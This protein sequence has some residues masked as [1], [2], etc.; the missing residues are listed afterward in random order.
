M[1]VQKEMRCMSETYAPLQV[2]SSFESRI[3]IKENA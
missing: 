1:V 3:Y 2:L